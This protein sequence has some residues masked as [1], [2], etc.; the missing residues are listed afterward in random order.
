MRTCNINIGPYHE[1]KMRTLKMFNI[2]LGIWI[3]G[4]LLLPFLR[5][6]YGDHTLLRVKFATELC[7]SFLPPV[8]AFAGEV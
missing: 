6:R 3:R 4:I 7:A 5:P 8:S 1:F 2:F